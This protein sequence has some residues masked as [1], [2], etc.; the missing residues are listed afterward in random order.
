M[1]PQAYITAW[2]KKAPWQED[3]QVEQD[4]VIE[5]TLM[6]IYSDEY[7]KER[8]AFRGG[9]ALHKLFLSPAARYSEDID[10]VQITG[11]PFGPI[12]DRLREALL[13]L[14]DKPIRKQKQH[15]N[16]LIYRVTSEGGIPLRLKVEVNCRE[17]HTIFGIH[18]VKYAMQ[19]EWYAAEVSIP[20]Y[21][22]PELLGTKMRALYQRRKGRDLFDMWLAMTK[23]NVE[24]NEIIEAWKFYLTKEGNSI[25]QK[26]FIENM[27]KKIADK[28]FIGDMEGLLRPD[29]P[30]KIYAAYEFVKSELLENI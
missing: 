21:T 1:I 29:Q 19:S 6:A 15:N 28:D 4:L 7:L 18:N 2:R 23:H 14:G 25:S 10:L 27:E 22:L 26:S 11:E 12:M 20:T 30:Y 13:F 3:F 8:L 9:T 5:R 17:H 24:P 16:T